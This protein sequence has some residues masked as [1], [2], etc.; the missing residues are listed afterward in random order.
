MSNSLV[1]VVGGLQ[2]KLLGALP[3]NELERVQPHL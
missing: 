2:N 1:S 3:D